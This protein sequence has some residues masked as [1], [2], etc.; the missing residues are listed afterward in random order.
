[1]SEDKKGINPSRRGSGRP[2]A[3]EDAVPHPRTGCLLCGAPLV[4]LT[5]LAS[6][7]CAVCGELKKGDARCGQG[8]FICDVCHRQAA[9]DR[10]RKAMTETEETDMVRLFMDVRSRANLPMHGPEHH[11]LVPGVILATYR[12]LGG[13]ISRED[14]L[15][16]IERGAQVP[17][18]YCGFVG[19]CGA[20][21]GVGIAFGVILGSNPLS[22]GK[23]QTVQKVVAEVISRLAERR[24]ARCCNRESLLSLQAAA[25]LS[26]QFLPV[27]LRA[28]APAVCGQHEGNRECI[29]KACP[30]FE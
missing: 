17:G 12:N 23:R 6:Q 29:R 27:T 22:P 11:A 15:A 13:E 7:T 18:G 14:I 20:A 25:E 10:I 3:R 9:M 30:F 24:A 5:G 2:D 16:G 19:A 21:M 1:M 28:D 26:R 8:H 4:Y